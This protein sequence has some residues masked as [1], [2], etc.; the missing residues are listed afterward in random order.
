MLLFSIP[1]PNPRQDLDKLINLSPFLSLL[2]RIDFTNDPAATKPISK[3]ANL[4]NSAVLRMLEE[5]EE[6]RRQG[7]D[8]GESLYSLLFIL[9]NLE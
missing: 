9:L 2:S 7:V 6:Q 1:F 8:P 3:P 5:Q 4:A